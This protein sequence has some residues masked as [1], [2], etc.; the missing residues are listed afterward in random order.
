MII[1]SESRI[2]TVVLSNENCPI[3]DQSQQFPPL[4]TNEDNNIILKSIKLEYGETKFI[5][6]FCDKDVL[7]PTLLQSF[8]PIKISKIIGIE[9]R[10]SP[11]F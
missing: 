9:A 8:V 10:P 11:T 6:F 7:T 3:F 2:E 5:A 4:K 1:N